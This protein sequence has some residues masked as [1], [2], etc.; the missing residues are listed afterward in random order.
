LKQAFTLILIS[1][2]IPLVVTIVLRPNALKDVPLGP[3]TMPK[4]GRF[5]MTKKNV[6]D[7]NIVFGTVPMGYRNLSKKA[8]LL[9]NATLA[10]TY[11]NR[12]KTQLALMPVLCAA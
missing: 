3:C 7:V 11:G 5:S 1:I 4:T 9:A 2:I 6:S 8:V 12:A 10:W